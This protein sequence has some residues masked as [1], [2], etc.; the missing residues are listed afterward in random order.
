MLLSWFRRFALSIVF[1]FAVGSAARAQF[2]LPLNHVEQDTKAEQMR[3]LVSK[4]CR[5][6]YD[7]ARMDP[8]GW[9]KLQSLVWWK[10]SPDYTQMNVISRYTIGFWD[11]LKP[12]L[13]IHEKLRIPMR[14]WTT[15]SLQSTTSGALTMPNRTFPIPRGR[16]C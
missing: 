10:T 14:T 16:P 5:L 4:Y 6:D 3:E 8:Q 7:G 11:D 13:V 2:P 1:L 15:S 9:P 12:A